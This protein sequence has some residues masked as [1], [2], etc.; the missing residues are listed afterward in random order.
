MGTVSK[1]QSNPSLFKCRDL[2]YEA[3][4]Y[5]MEDFI[6]TAARSVFGGTCALLAPAYI[7]VSPKE[8][9]GI[10]D[11]LKR[12][13]DKGS[14]DL[15]FY[16]MT[17]RLHIDVADVASQIAS[18]EG[19]FILLKVNYFGFEDPSSEELYGMVQR[20]GGLLL[21]DNAH[22]FFTYVFRDSD[23]FDACFFSLHKQFPFPDG[24]MLRL[25]D[26][27]LQQLAYTPTRTPADYDLWNYDFKAIAKTMRGN[28][29]A[30]QNEALRDQTFWVSLRALDENDTYPVPQTYPLLLKGCD[31]YRVYEIMNDRGFGVTSLY[32]TM[33]PPIAGDDS[34]AASQRIA[35][36]VLNIPVHQDVDSSVYPAL[37]AELLDSCRMARD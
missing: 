22:A 5:A 32:H 37:F 21:E 30:A 19:A 18:V 17:E 26:P 7:G 13:S 31:R 4:R 6:A 15:R 35:Q 20:A 34:Y 11:P 23:Y 25:K 2:Y 3:A 1:I 12:L 33:I 27:G 29:L 8:G 9:S 28:F 14:I 10:Y 24:G 16:K 36:H